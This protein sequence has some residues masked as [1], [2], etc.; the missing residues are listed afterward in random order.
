MC[1][2]LANKIRKAKSLSTETHLHKHEYD[3]TITI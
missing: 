2:A 3:E 1:T